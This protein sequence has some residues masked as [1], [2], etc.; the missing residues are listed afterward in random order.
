[1]TR[2]IMT[3][4]P[5]FIFFSLRFLSTVEPV[6]ARK[7]VILM[8]PH[9]PTHDPSSQVPNES[10]QDPHEFLTN[11]HEPTNDRSSRVSN[12]SSQD[13]LEFATSPR[14]RPT[15]PRRC[16]RP[17]VRA[18]TRP[19]IRASAHP[20]IRASAHPRC[21]RPRIRVSAR[22]RIRASVQLLTHT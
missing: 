15:N 10:S 21:A 1:M 2:C 12:E 18:S 19:R 20:R 8:N 3:G 4:L 22:P 16:P 5:S 14:K 9:E 17:L 6:V 13:H 11:P 7:K